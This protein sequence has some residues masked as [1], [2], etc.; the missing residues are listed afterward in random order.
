MRK[1]T[2]SNGSQGIYPSIDRWGYIREECILASFQHLYRMTGNA[3]NVK[4][5][6][7]PKEEF[8]ALEKNVHDRK[9]I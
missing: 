5:E 4:I 2:G 8:D 3:D 9:Y 6:P 7:F 1:A